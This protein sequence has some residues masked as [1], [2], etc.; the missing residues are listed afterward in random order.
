M[1]E[2]SWESLRPAKNDRACL[3][4]A[5]GC[6]K[7]TLAEYLVNDPEKPYSVVYD[8]K[9]SDNIGGWRNQTIYTSFEELQEAEEPR[10]VY[11]PSMEESVDPQ[12]QDDFFGWV[13]HRQWTRLYVDEAYA[14][15][16]GSNPSFYLQACMSRGRERGIST[17]IATQ[18][19]KRIPLITISE[20]EHFYI[21]RLNLLEDKMRV[22]EITNISIEEQ[23]EL[24]NYE[25]IYYNGLTGERSPKLKLKL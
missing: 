18:R 16:G 6:G 17:F 11:R 8:A 9:I 25:F 20:S 23:I 24:R 5:T 4:G 1:R 21:F 3:I 12:A 2:F 10:L 22:Y 14:L 15:L 19:P 13:Y 7:T